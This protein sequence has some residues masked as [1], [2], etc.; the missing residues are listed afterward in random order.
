MKA[1]LIGAALAIVAAVT[2]GVAHVRADAV[3]DTTRD[4]DS[5][6][7]IK[8]GT[9]TATEMRKEYDT[10]GT[11][12][13]NGSTLRQGDIHK[14]YSAM[15]ISR[16]DLNGEFRSG[17]VYKNGDVKVN[18]KV[19]AHNAKTAARNLGGS[20]I[21]G[22]S[23]GI[24]DTSKMGSAQTALVKFNKNGEFEFAVMKPCGNPVKATP[25]KVKHPSAKCEGI[26][27]TK[28]SRNEFKFDGKASVKDGAKIKSY[29]FTA[30]DAKGK[31]V[32]TKTVKTDKLTANSGKMTFNKPGTYKVRLT[33][34]STAGKD[35]T[36]EHCVTEITVKPEPKPGVSIEKKVNGKE[37]ITVNVNQEF[38]YNITVKNTGKVDLK[39]V[40][41]SD[42]Q[43]A[44][45]QFISASAGT[46]AGGTW[47]YT[48]PELKAG[49]SKN[50]TIKAKVTEYQEG[51][52]K[53]TA[54]VDAPAIPGNPDDCDDAFVKVPKP[55]ATCD[56]LKVN[57]LSKN[58]FTLTG[59]ASVT[60]KATVSAYVFTI[61][62]A[63]GA[64]VDTETVTTAD[65]QAT[66]DKL[67]LTTPG[68]YA[69]NLVVKT[70]VGDR[71]SKACNATIK[72]PESNMV[73]VCDPATGQIITVPEEEADNYKPVND[74][75]CQPPQPEQIEVCELSTHNII[76]INKVDFD[77][78]LHSTDLSK[79]DEPEETVEVCD[80]KTGQ[81]ITVPKGQE[82]NYKPVDDQAC[83]EQPEVLVNTGAGSVL[84]LMASVT[85][86]GALAHRYVW[87]P[88]RNG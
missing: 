83:E 78:N 3:V 79:C 64:V 39:N 76:T 62:D 1:K 58:D 57:Y 31:V 80:P 88:R 61:K 71:T 6:S 51:N 67:T 45:V 66:T 75:A 46:I 50:F 77:A 86:A 32:A 73:Q 15:G 44:G 56:L 28:V 19:V 47:T 70:S 12:N 35:L 26:S 85:I 53:N 27:K 49:Q 14:I 52:I 34:D 84:G 17:V 40:A 69:V 54:C 48:I 36:S 5:F 18:G 87:L 23:A 43:P 24:V 63:S 20:A 29:T 2:F 30:R 25:V 4:C 9:M 65:L 8:C 11:S 21:A 33:V 7:I 41:V 74:P 82:G 42:K 37:N 60:N 81:I 68:T 72:I 16:S 55:S 22:T 59:K 13:A 10:F 38:N